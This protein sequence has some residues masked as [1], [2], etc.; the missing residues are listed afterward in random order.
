MDLL[1]GSYVRV[2]SEYQ[3]SLL[4]M[5]VTNCIFCDVLLQPSQH[6]L[7]SSSSEEHI[8]A[9]WYRD[10]VVNNKLK[11]FTA[12]L[13][14]APVL[15]R[16]PPLARLVNNAVCR[17]CNSG[18]MSKLETDIAPIF[19]SLVNGQDISTLAPEEI[20]SLARWTAKTA[21]VLSYVTPQ[22]ARVPRTT[23]LSLHPDSKVAPQMRF[24][25]ARIS[26]DLTLEGGHL[27]LVYGPELQ[28]V[29]TEEV[30]GTRITL[31]VYN[32]CLTVDFPPMTAGIIY[33]LT[34]SCSA[35]L[36]PRFIAAGTS[37]LALKGPIPISDALFAIC[38]RIK[39]GYDV[40]VL[41][42]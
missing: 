24:F 15:I 34:E 6:N 40:N 30:C 39:V 42:A 25:Y 38:S 11:M 27:Q 26:A 32:H 5:N 19:E 23:T 21:A 12:T 1:D 41:R 10:N 8:Y 35:L 13:G 31:C 36:W 14:S 7:P 22:D 9:R 4:I 37:E 16:Q 33:D 2:N 28:L 17:T 18:W 20:E 29:G 3:D